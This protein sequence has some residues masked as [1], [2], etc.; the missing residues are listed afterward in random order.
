MEEYTACRSVLALL[1]LPLRL[2]FSIWSHGSAISNVEISF[3]RQA[4]S[5]LH[6][7]RP[8]VSSQYMYFVGQCSSL[9]TG[10]CNEEL[11]FLCVP[12]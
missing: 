1:G 3:V 12:A 5:L 2:C 8:D 6:L 7:I 11:V 9:D 4:I 10:P